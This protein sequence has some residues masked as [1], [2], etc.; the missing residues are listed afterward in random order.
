[1]PSSRVIRFTYTG[2]LGASSG[3]VVGVVM[4]SPRPSMPPWASAVTWIQSGSSRIFT[5]WW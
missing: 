4:N 1:M 3:S 2:N 5:G